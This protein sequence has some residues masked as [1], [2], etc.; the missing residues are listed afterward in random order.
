M[1]T[2]ALAHL[3]VLDMDGKVLQS[4]GDLSGAPGE[5]AALTIF[6]MLHDVHCSISPALSGNGFSKL[7]VTD[8]SKRYIITVKNGKIYANLQLL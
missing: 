6:K 2:S 4:S 5:K 1:E 8:E 3:L 7:T